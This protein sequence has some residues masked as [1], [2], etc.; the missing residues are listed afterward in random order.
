VNVRI[1]RLE[2]KAIVRVLDGLA[3]EKRERVHGRIDRAIEE[4]RLD[5]GSGNTYACPL[6]ETGT[7]CLV[8][9]E[10]K[11][12]PCIQHACYENE[13]DL[14]P[15]EL[16]AQQEGLIDQLNRRVYGTSDGLAPIPIAVSRALR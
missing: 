1:S 7:G 2:A 4:Y 6:F 12:L 11:P 5:T 16:L 15:D 14:P 3:E 10:A 8:H 13:K 9:S